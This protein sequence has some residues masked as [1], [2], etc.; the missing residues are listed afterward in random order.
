MEQTPYPNILLHFL[1]LDYIYSA[2]LALHLL[3]LFKVSLPLFSL[4]LKTGIHTL[5]SIET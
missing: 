5:D 2:L 4:Q 1:S 3:Y